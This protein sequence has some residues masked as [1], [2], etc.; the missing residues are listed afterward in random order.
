MHCNRSAN[1]ACYTEICVRTLSKTRS[2]QYYERAKLGETRELRGT[3]NVQG[4]KYTISDLTWSI[5]DPRDV[6]IFLYA[7]SS[8]FFK[9]FKRTV[10]EGPLTE[11][12]FNIFTVDETRFQKKSNS[13][14]NVNKL[15]NKVTQV[16]LGFRVRALFVYWVWNDLS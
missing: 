5:S 10:H 14:F 8:F 2:E 12:H 7:C 3:D 6:C 11:Y 13:G 16:Y 1:T 15:F 9:F 4:E